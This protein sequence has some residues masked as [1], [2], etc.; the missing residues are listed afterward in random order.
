MDELCGKTQLRKIQ[1]GSSRAVSK[2]PVQENQAWK[3]HRKTKS[4]AQG[5]TLFELPRISGA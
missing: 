1:R 5:A 4:A 3:T 2:K